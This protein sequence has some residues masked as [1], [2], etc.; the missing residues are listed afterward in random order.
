LH[1]H[2]FDGQI[3]HVWKSGWEYAFSFHDEVGHQPPAGRDWVCIGELEWRVVGDHF[4]HELLPLVQ[5]SE[6][7]LAERTRRKERHQ[8]RRL[9]MWRICEM[10]NTAKVR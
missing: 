3:V 2:H 6:R 1:N 8:R 7:E 9:R 5:R 4:V 10:E